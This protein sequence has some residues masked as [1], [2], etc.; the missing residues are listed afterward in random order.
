MAF[1]G[2]PVE[3]TFAVLVTTELT[4]FQDGVYT[5]FLGSDEGS[6]LKIDGD[7]VIDN[8]GL[9]TFDEESAMIFL[10][11]GDYFLELQYFENT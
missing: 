6:I 5:F 1:P 2:F 9:Q 3:D 7:V 8:G 4:I 10:P 11:A